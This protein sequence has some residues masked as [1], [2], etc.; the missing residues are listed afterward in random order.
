[1]GG[2]GREGGEERRETMVE[3]ESKGVGVGCDCK[4]ELTD[5]EGGG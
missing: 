2:G 5:S 1:M 3:N 4:D